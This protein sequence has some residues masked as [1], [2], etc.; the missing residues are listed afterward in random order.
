MIIYQVINA[1]YNGIEFN[2]N[3]LFR[4]I[5]NTFCAPDGGA[6]IIRRCR[7]S[8]KHAE[9]IQNNII[10]MAQVRRKNRSAAG[11]I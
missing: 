4:T 6:G 9:K 5:L 11:I 3:P 7:Q 8:C 10:I 1:S 2:G